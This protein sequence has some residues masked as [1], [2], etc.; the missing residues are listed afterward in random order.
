MNKFFLK[1]FQMLSVLFFKSSAHRTV[2]HHARIN[3]DTYFHS[4]EY[5]GEYSFGYGVAHGE[6]LIYLFHF[7]GE[8][9]AEDQ[10]LSDIMVD[11]WTNFAYNG[12]VVCG[13]FL[14]LT[15]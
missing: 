12:Y 14:N 8:L 3:A 7:A 15:S 1:I 13:N 9:N 6:D 4:F 11:Y 2:Q 5:T 10:A